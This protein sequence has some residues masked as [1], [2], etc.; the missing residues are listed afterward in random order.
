MAMKENEIEG[1]IRP[2]SHTDPR[3]T[4]NIEG[5]WYAPEESRMR[6]PAIS[7]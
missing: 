2:R 3:T 5:R 4:A 1:F 6:K 7:N